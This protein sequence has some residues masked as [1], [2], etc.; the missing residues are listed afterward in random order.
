MESL[1]Q[2][3]RDFRTTY[4]YV[5]EFAQ[6]EDQRGSL[7]EIAIEQGPQDA[8]I[9]DL[10]LR[11]GKYPQLYSLWK[12]ITSLRNK[13]LSTWSNGYGS[14]RVVLQNVCL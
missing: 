7:W 11:P 10:V 13:Q 9:A 4:H 1:D 5:L 14:K 8:A 3:Q 12:T 2:R 6:H